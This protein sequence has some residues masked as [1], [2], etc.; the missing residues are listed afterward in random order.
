MTRTLLIVASLIAISGVAYA[1]DESDPFSSAADPFADTQDPF[2]ALED[3]V[4]AT[5][6]T[7]KDSAPA[8]PSTAAPTPT[9]TPASPAPSD[10][11][12]SATKD[13]PAAKNTPGFGV[14][15]SIGAIGV[16]LVALRRR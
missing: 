8:A 12:A 13:A 5:E 9:P 4:T 2:A 10:S 3:N 16:A 6:K 1:Q 15:A 7:L 11:G 14:V